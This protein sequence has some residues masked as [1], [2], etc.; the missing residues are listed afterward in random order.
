MTQVMWK[1]LSIAL[2]GLFVSLVQAADLPGLLL[3]ETYDAGTD[4]TTYL[5][6]EKLD[7]VR[8][9]W[10]GESLRFRSGRPISVPAWFTAGWPRIPMDGE[11]WLG[12]GQFETLS[13]IVRK[14]VP[15]DA[16]WRRVRYMLFELPGAEGDF[17]ERYARMGPLVAKVGQPWLQRVEQSRVSSRGQL[18]Q[19]L[20]KV[21]DAGGEGLM[22]H[23]ANAPYVAGRSR[24]LLKLK[25]YTDREA[26]VVAHLPGTGRNAHRLGALLVEDEGRQFRIGTGFS[27][28]ERRAPPPIGAQ[29]TYR[30]QGRTAAGL[31]RFP[32]FLRQRDPE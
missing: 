25:P 18:M 30:Y 16:D 3:A 1:A 7:G 12:H 23:R 10:D 11:L 20:Q 24:D 21:V 17:S 14:Q 2:I 9:V 19:R 5:V 8:A 13:G 31:P 27:D 32:S 28:A 29:I 22:L 6:S 15:V 26:V 4:P